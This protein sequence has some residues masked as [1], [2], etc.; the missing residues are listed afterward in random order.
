MVKVKKD[1]TGQQFG[2]L[3]VLYQTEDHID[4]KGKHRAKYHCI[5]SC[6]KHNEIDVLMC[7]LK[8]GKTQSCGCLQKEQTSISHKKYNEYQIVN[9]VVYIKLSNCDEYTI[10]NFDKWNEVPWIREF[11]W[12]KGAYGYVCS[13]IP[14]EYRDIFHKKHIKLHQLI[15]SCEKG[16]EP[17]HLDRNPLNN[18]T[19]NLV[20]KTHLEN[21]QNKNHLERKMHKNNTSGVE[22][23]HW[24]KRINK[25]QIQINVNNKRIHLGYSDDLNE[26]IKIRKEAE[27]YYWQNK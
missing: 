12:Y 13:D 3:T 17:D 15:C 27:K 10:V 11:C 4:A 16:F 23:V 1:L 8:N 14:I 9:D 2:R 7:D 22:G 21:M 20:A 19:N 18:L 25:W 24:N 5:C 6:E 26:A